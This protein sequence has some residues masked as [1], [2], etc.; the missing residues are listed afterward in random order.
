[1]TRHRKKLIFIRDSFFATAFIFAVIGLA[2]IILINSQ[3]FNPVHLAITDLDLIDVG[4]S[5][6]KLNKAEGKDTNVVIFNIGN[7]NRLE[8]ARKINVLNKFKP[9]VIALDA[10]FETKNKLES[11]P[12]Y[13]RAL[14]E[15]IEQTPNLVTGNYFKYYEQQSKTDCIRLIASDTFFNLQ[16][17]EGYMN[18]IGNKEYNTIRFFVPKIDSPDQ[19]YLSITTRI[20]RKYNFAMFR[21]LI[22]RNS[23]I[24]IIRYKGNMGDYL[25]YDSADVYA[26]NQNLQF[27]KGKIVLMGRY[28]ATPQNLD[29]TD[30]HFTPLN[31]NYVG[32][33]L[34]DMYG[35]AI[36]ANILSMIIEDKYIYSI[37][38]FWMYFFSFLVCLLHVMLFQYIFVNRHYWYAGLSTL[39]ALLSTLV[40]FLLSLFFYF[41]VQVKIDAT[42]LILPFVLGAELIYYYEMIVKILHKKYKFESYLAHH[43]HH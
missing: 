27:I 25:T 17:R 6:F 29:Y 11:N 7:D 14:K 13:D 33:S 35:V 37:P 18:L 23:P 38:R 24:E 22:R 4:Y 34:P 28:N 5:K 21:K 8:I 9:A 31:D 15:A 1:M 43:V 41:A 26:N 39:I 42:L 30:K 32:R 16:E 36:H 12:E 40:V 10:V 2:N 19:T 3:A 20:I